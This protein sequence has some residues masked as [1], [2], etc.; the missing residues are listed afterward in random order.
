MRHLKHLAVTALAAMV[1]IFSAAQGTNNAP[2]TWEDIDYDG[3]PWVENVSEPWKPTKGL[4]NRHLSLWASHGRYYDVKRGGWKWQRPSMFCTTEDLFT[5]SI[6]VPYLIPM[7]ENSGACVFTPRERDWQRNEVI[8]DNDDHT[9]G[10]NYIEV[11]TKEHWQ[12]AGLQG[13][14]RREGMLLDGENPFASGTVRL[15]PAIKKAKKASLVSYQPQIPEAGRYA[16]YVSYATLEKSADDVTYTVWHKGQETHFRVNQRMGGGTWVY[17]GSF[18]FDEGCNEFN[19]VVVSNLSSRKHAVVTTDAVRFGG[20][21]GNIARL[22]LDGVYL[23]QDTTATGHQL[24]PSPRVSGLPRCLEGARYYAH[25]AGMPYD[26]YSGRQG[27]DDYADDINSRSCMTNY[28]GGGSVYMPNQKGLRVP[29]ELSLGVHSDAGYGQCDSIVGTLTICTTDFNNG[30]LD[31]GI[32]R[33]ASKNFAKR[34]LDE[35]PADI[36]KVYGKW[37]KRELYDRNY[38]ESRVPAVP[39]AILETMSHQNYNDM[40]YGHDPNFKFTLARAIYKSILRYVSDMH[41]K[42]YAVAPLAPDHFAISMDSDGEATLTWQA[43]SDPSEPTAEP[44]GYVVYTST[45]SAGFD[46]GTHVQGTKTKVRL[47]PGVLYSFRVAAVNKGG[48]SFP[49]EVLSAAYTPGAKSTVMIVN[50]FNRLASPEVK[51]EADSWRFDI[52][53]DPGISYGKTA[54]WLGRQQD[55]NP[56]TAGKEGPGGLGYSDE[57]LMGLFVAG[58]DFNYVATHARA[59]HSAGLYNIISCSDEALASGSADLTHCDMAD[60]IFGLER[61]DGY[62]L[63]KYEVMSAALRRSLEDFTGRGGSLL[64]SGAYVASDMA[65][66]NRDNATTS[67]LNNIL[68]CHLAGTY[69]SQ[70]DAISGLGTSMQFHHQLNEQHY[71]ATR[72]DILSPLAPAFATMLYGNGNAACVAYQGDDYRAVTMGFPFECIKGEKKQGIVMRALARFL[73]KN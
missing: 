42:D 37:N 3:H 53:A 1:S 46:N 22:P 59:L 65:A 70:N 68:K 6:V 50:A 35:I 2:A 26:V 64:V 28:V 19:R 44:T 4:H 69:D 62:S 21:M 24:P 32:S 56:A 25:W 14:S 61:N 39:S 52:D 58:N 57:S 48:R 54:T 63:M 40:R 27:T 10:V 16:V 5:Q 7:L 66:R 41:G 45:G 67:F 8:V 34:L 30:L 71:A 20:G 72:T 11:N 15:C 29:I 33:Q 31:A 38:S 13:F 9:P 55:C 60:V 23:P 18:E 49:T 51:M 17:L 36:A 73:L 47:E 12:D 43:V